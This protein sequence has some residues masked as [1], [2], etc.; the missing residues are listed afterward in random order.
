MSLLLINQLKNNTTLTPLQVNAAVLLITS[1]SHAILSSPP[2]LLGKASRKWKWS[3]RTRVEHLGI[4]SNHLRKVWDLVKDR[5][6]IPRKKNGKIN[7]RLYYK[8]NSLAPLARLT[9]VI[10]AL[11]NGRKLTMSEYQVDKAYI[12]REFKHMIPIIGERCTFIDLPKIWVKHPFERVAGA[13]DCT[14]HFRCRVHPNQHLYYRGDKHGHFIS[15]QVVCDLEG[16]LACV[17]FFSGRL[18]DQACF[19]ESGL[20]SLL[21]KLNVNLL[22][23]LGY[24]DFHLVTPLSHMPADWR[25]IQ[26]GMRSVVENINGVV[27][28][29]NYAS[30]RV[31]GHHPQFQAY[32]LLVIYN[33]VALVLEEFPLRSPNYLVRFTSPAALH[34]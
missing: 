3:V 31:R 7:K 29:W 34:F 8:S 22:A 2:R 33:L 19:S 18:N 23:D 11:R 21:E 15:A 27:E 4:Y 32:C 24:H 6:R 30:E 10:S 26:A 14:T 25:A 12:T 16:K 17:H 28:K 5:I 1:Q 20:Q 9:C 13:V